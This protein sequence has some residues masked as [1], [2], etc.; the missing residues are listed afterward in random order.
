MYNITSYTNRSDFS[1]CREEFTRP[2]CYTGN[3]C[4]L[5]TVGKYEVFVQVV[6]VGSSKTKSITC[7]NSTV[8]EMC[9]KGYYCPNPYEKRI[10]SIGYYCPIGVDKQIS[11]PFGSGTCPDSATSSPKIIIVWLLLTTVIVI[12]FL[13]YRWLLKMVIL[14][15]DKPRTYN[16]S[17]SLI[18]G[19]QEFATVSSSSEK[20]L[21]TESS[22]RFPQKFDLESLKRIISLNVWDHC[23]IQLYKAADSNKRSVNMDLNVIEDIPM[24]DIIN[25][26][27]NDDTFH[28]LH[29]DSP[30]SLSSTSYRM[31]NETSME[32]IYPNDDSFISF[33]FEPSIHSPGESSTSN[34][35][36]PNKDE[37]SNNTF[38]FSEVTE[39]I[40]ISFRGLNLTLKS[41]QKTILHNVSGAVVHHRLT[42]VMG[43]SGAGKTTLLS[44]LRGIAHYADVTGELR[45]NG[46][47][48]SS[49]AGYRQRMAFVSQDSIMYDELSVEDNIK[50]SAVL[51]NQRGFTKLEQLWP[52]VEA[53]EEFMEITSIR[54]MIVGNVK[55]RGISGGEKKRVSIA[56]ELV[57]E[58]SL[59]FL[60]EPTSGLD[61][62]TS[63]SIIRTLHHLCDLGVNVVAT[64]HQPRQEILQLMQDLI[65]LAPEGRVVYCGPV[66]D[67]EN[68]FSSL[69][70]VC[71]ART[72]IADFA[73]DVLH[74]MMFEDGA[75]VLFPVEEVVSKL[76][77]S[78]DVNGRVRIEELMSINDAA[79]KVP[80]PT[81]TSNTTTVTSFF[82]TLQFCCRRQFKVA[83]RGIDSLLLSCLGH[84]VFG[85]LIGKLFGSVQLSPTSRMTSPQPA[86]GQLVFMLL[87]QACSAKHFQFD[88]LMRL[89]EESS[90]IQ[91]LPYFIG[92]LIGLSTDVL[93]FSLSFNVG[94]YPFI[95]SRASFVE[96]WFPYFHFC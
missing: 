55:K 58:S 66:I 80:T 46:H 43:P 4:I 3:F 21:A 50:Y 78:W 18:D 12:I 48:V 42:A 59:F 68:T 54:T 19:Q 17:Q 71:E 29:L 83:S 93:F 51:F 47:C 7:T 44:L 1:I 57:K 41:N 15:K 53:A 38:Q 23:S 62:A 33:H 87:I 11:C 8:R 89:H 16:I 32:D 24:K 73:M 65:L 9:P 39:P 60:D 20:S 88:K 37:T 72:N 95:E 82:T 77:N 96:Y 14:W 36:M 94:Y 81:S 61:S 86:C 40:S 52:M 28:P 91:I 90:G 70:F 6:G 76:T 30:T 56:M 35:R 85:I 31:Q 84:M 25:P 92:K 67:L 49:L 63:L 79:E 74:G 2:E 22:P 13:F 69:G 64:L 45:V 10:C 5:N 27:H 34:N 75:L 26:Y